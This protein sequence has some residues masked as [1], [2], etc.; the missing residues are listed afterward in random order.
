MYL[1]H[2]PRKQIAHTAPKRTIRIAVGGEPSPPGVTL[3]DLA[4]STDEIAKFNGSNWVCDV[5][6]RV[7][8]VFASST[9]SDGDLGGL[10]G[11]DTECNVLAANVGLSGELVAWLST[12]S[13][14]AV[15]RLAGSVGPWLNTGG[16]MVAA[17]LVDLARGRVHHTIHLDEDGFDA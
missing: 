7:K 9:I 6:R 14:N 8:F 16:E 12:D 1:W 17:S 15:D 13:V 5:D 2:Q 4:C 10:E 11:A 3:G